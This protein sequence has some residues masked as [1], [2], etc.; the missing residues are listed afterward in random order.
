MA[1]T[2][3]HGED[4]IQSGTI[5][6]AQIHTSAAIA[7]T[8]L[9]DG[10]SFF[11]K[12]GSIAATGDFDLGSFK[13]TNLAN[14]TAANDAVNL[15]Q[16][17]AAQSGLN[18]K[19][20]V[21]AATTG[22]ATLATD[23]ENG[24]TLDGVT[25][26]TGDRILIKDQSS[27][28]EN[29]IYTVNASG[30]PT[31]ATDADSTA[32][33]PFNVFV[34]VREGTTN[35]DTGWVTTNDTAITLNTTA[36]VFTQ[37][38]GAGSIT[39]GAGL[40][41]TGNT[42]DVVSGNT[43]IVANANDITLTLRSTPGLQ[44]SSGLGILLASNSGLNLTS[45]LSVDSSIAGAGIGFSSGVL[46]IAADDTSVTIGTDGISVRL[47]TNPG[48]EVSTGLKIKLD[49][50]SLSLSSSGL[51]V[52]PAGL[53]VVGASLPANNIW[54]GS[55]SDVA[56][57]LDMDILAG[58]E[59]F[60]NDAFIGVNIAALIP[61]NYVPN[62]PPSS[63]SINGTNDVFEFEGGTS[64][65]GMKVYLN[66]ILQFEGASDDYVI[67]GTSEVTFNTAPRT[68]QRVT[69]SYWIRS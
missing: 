4:Q 65:Y 33:W 69:A 35:A 63:G 28:A 8:K 13:I 56:Q 55:P 66:G 32:E 36:I 50:S 7:T 31:R 41:K 52:N 40:T 23:F 53:S 17:Q 26:A 16:L 27:G 61:N 39:A 20:A 24:D 14:G 54:S 18:V 47:A 44:I 46:S 60:I 22:P 48:L 2:Q 6:N 15:S 49:G 67:T 10:P 51:K 38:T 29:G 37:F 19:A 3:I 43:G 68:G 45:G 25:L 11:W 62:S 42:I 59:L 58:Q 21:R 12:D 5:K 34:F 64:T 57:E 9:A 1:V 30:A